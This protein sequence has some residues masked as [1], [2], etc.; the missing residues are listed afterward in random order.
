MG[1]FIFLCLVFLY[2]VFYFS[3]FLLDYIKA[4]TWDVCINFDLMI[5]IFFLIKLILLLPLSFTLYP[6]PLFKGK[7]C[8]VQGWEWIEPLCNYLLCRGLVRIIVQQKNEK[9][10]LVIYS[11]KNDLRSVVLLRWVKVPYCKRL[12]IL[13]SY[14]I[15]FFLCIPSLDNSAQ[16]KPAINEWK[17]Y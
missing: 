6:L 16:Y 4:N 11:Q 9:L 1:S 7:R 17:A 3:W 8:L 12:E 15:E 14:S 10:Y 2:T 5:Q 13:A